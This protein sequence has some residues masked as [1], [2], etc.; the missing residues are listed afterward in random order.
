MSTQNINSLRLR[1][2]ALAGVGSF[3]TCWSFTARAQQKQTPPPQP[4]LRA[5]QVAPAPAKTVPPP[6]AT[7]GNAPLELRMKFKPNDLSRYQMTMQ[8]DL[9]VPGMAQSAGGQYNTSLNMVIQQK[10]IKLHPDGSA[11]VAM[12][13]LSSNGVVNQQPIKPNISGKPSIITFDTRNNIVTARDLPQSTTGMDPTSRIFQS[14]ALSTQ[15]VYLP[16]QAVRIGDKWTQK[17]NVAGLGKDTMGTVQSKLVRLEPVGT[18]QTARLHSTINIPFVMVDKTVKPPVPLKGV[19]V[20]NY[21]SNLALGEGKV[22]R[23]TGDGDI[24]VVVNMPASSASK[25]GNAKPGKAAAANTPPPTQ[26]VSVRL[27]MGNNLMT[28]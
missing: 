11:D 4:S 8:A 6:A 1:R 12:T 27:R 17:I 18:F 26:K 9:Q 25:S 19:M 21:D 14:G 15:G 24:S 28:Q 7:P 3:L 16:K 10:V 22:V 2:V 23:S 5:T 20:M 13:T